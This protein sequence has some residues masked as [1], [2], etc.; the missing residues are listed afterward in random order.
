MLENLD[1][2][3]TPELRQQFADHGLSFY[4]GIAL[5]SI[6]EREAVIDAERPI[7]AGVFQNRL[8]DGWFLSSCPTVQYALGYR[9]DEETWWKPQLYFVDLEVVSPYNT[10]RNLGLPPAPIASPGLRSIQAAASPE[11]TEYYFFMVNCTKNDGSHFFAR[12]EAEHL[13][14]FEACGGVISSP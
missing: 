1:H 5:A 7:I 2:Q 11:E 9:P 12:T 8:R 6:V 13:Q 10:Y 14:N 4:E 3:V